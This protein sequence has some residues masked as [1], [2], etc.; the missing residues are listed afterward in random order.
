MPLAGVAGS[1]QM[2]PGMDPMAALQLQQ[3]Q[4]QAAHAEMV[5]QAFAEAAAKGMP[6]PTILPPGGLRPPGGH[7]GPGMVG[8][9]PGLMDTMA[10]MMGMTGLLGGMLGQAPDGSNLCTESAIAS[11]SGSN[12]QS[13]DSLEGATKDFMK[14]NM[15][16]PSFEEKLT[17]QLERMGDNWKQE[18]QR[19]DK[20]LESAGVPPI[21]RPQFL[22][23]NF[24]DIVPQ[25]WTDYDDAP[26]KKQQ[27]TV[28]PQ[29]CRS[30]MPQLLVSGQRQGQSQASKPRSRSR[31]R[32]R[33]R[34]RDKGKKD[35]S[36][37][38]RSR[39]RHRKSRSRSR[40][41]NKDH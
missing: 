26:P 5:K 33:S 39:S 6:Q 28:E 22:L 29:G 11:S 16:P 23:V 4:A 3:A 41:R 20:E 18:L 15:L 24:G 31:S 9:V 36:R 12:S 10:G 30:S 8:A 13:L 32:K 38:R 7:V 25:T 14:R 19:L 40:K 37:E 21:L 2:P 34:S 27:G 35:R 17:R 1:T